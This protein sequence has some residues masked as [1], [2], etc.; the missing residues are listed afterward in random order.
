MRTTIPLVGLGLALV[1]PL[2]CT[3]GSRSGEP[4][5]PEFAAQLAEQVPESEQLQLPVASSTTAPTPAMLM[6]LSAD[7]LTLDGV[8]LADVVDGRFPSAH[9]STNG[10][11]IRLRGA[12]AE[13][14]DD[15]LPPAGSTSSVV[16]PHDLRYLLLCH[17]D[18]SSATVAKVMRDSRPFHPTLVVNNPDL[19]HR[20]VL[21]TVMPDPDQE[22]YSWG[23]DAKEVPLNLTVY[24]DEAGF[25]VRGHFGKPDDRPDILDL[26]NSMSRTHNTVPLLEDGSHDFAGLTALLNQIKAFHPEVR[27]VFVWPSE[28]DCALSYETWIRTLDACPFPEKVNGYGGFMKGEG[29]SNR[30]TKQP[31]RARIEVVVSYPQEPPSDPAVIDKHLS[32]RRG[33]ILSCMENWANLYPV[34]NGTIEL[35]WRVSPKGHASDV[36]VLRDTFGIEEV[37]RCI[38]MRIVRLKF[39]EDDLGYA[40]T[41]A[42]TV[43]VEP[44]S[45]EYPVGE[46]GAP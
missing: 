5:V 33:S 39:P 34:T 35:N 41:A 25:L 7:A 36:N 4:I 21:E 1:L 9:L 8:E 11:I 30:P 24:I 32:R 37:A 40:V 29:M 16:S 23:F 43:T 10:E 28:A 6:V 2:S 12:L 45:E 15:V 20:T 26:M 27:R 44:H 17:E 13:K 42:Y 38:E 22:L 3:C 31:W 14:L 19:G 46:E 18:I